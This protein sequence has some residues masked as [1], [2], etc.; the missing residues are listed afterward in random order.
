MPYFSI[1]LYPCN[2]GKSETSKAKKEL[3]NLYLGLQK[4]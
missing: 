4:K 2:T 3:N 1:I